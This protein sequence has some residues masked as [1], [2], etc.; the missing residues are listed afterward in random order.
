MAALIRILIRCYGIVSIAF[1]VG[2][3]SVGP[4]YE[5]SDPP[6]P[7][8]WHTPLK[9]GL[10]HGETDPVTLAKWW[11]VLNDPDLNRLVRRA[12]T[13]SL[14]LK[15]ALARLR[16]ARARRFI[17]EADRFPT[18][19]ATGTATRSR[20][21]ENAGSGTT[22]TLYSIGFDA[23]WE[24]DVFG[25]V[26]RTVEAAE[27]DYMA[28]REDL[29]DVMVSLMAEVV[30]NYIE[31]RTIQARLATAQMSI[32]NQEETYQLTRWRFEAGL[33]DELDER[34]ARAS[35]EST[36]SRIPTL[37]TSLEEAKNRLAV[38]TG[39]HSGKLHKDLENVRPVPIIPLTIAVGV[40]ADVLR[41]RPDVRK[42]EQ[43][44]AAQTARV[45]VA[46]ADLYP[47]LTLN[48]SI[49]FDALS[50]GDLLSSGS[51]S[52][53]YGPRITWRI[54]DAGAVRRNIEVQSSKQQQALI[55][56]ESAVL[57]AL[58]ETENAL[59]A[60]AE[61]QQ[62]RD[63]LVEAV[64]AA[65]QALDLAQ[66][67]YQTGLIDFMV[68]LDTQ[69]SLLAYQDELD[70][71]DGTVTSNLVRLYKALGG[72]WTAQTPENKLNSS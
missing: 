5:R 13:G 44:L 26:R 54:F 72:G 14:D 59:A 18:L 63:S 9:G 20:D 50:T 53:S 52:Y 58:E 41:Q 29:R 24:I 17:A 60:Y 19:D 42:A 48:G 34:R 33:S 21:S 23:G 71:S 38:L 30:L 61:E 11:I 12:V 62:R 51:R 37:R 57:K 64:R 36:R 65:Q 27:A 3:A 2:C 31:M 8:V 46:E 32:K 70:Q 22:R 56:Y 47:K 10:I 66:F 15:Q 28:S 69:R 68:L 4:D 35:L 6:V 43:E 67:K 40:P 1:L 55:A 45:G 39:T 49:G 16:E 7:G 25:G